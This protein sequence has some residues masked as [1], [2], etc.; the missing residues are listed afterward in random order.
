LTALE[1]IPGNLRPTGHDIK[2]VIG[3]DGVELVDVLAPGRPT[4]R[5]TAAEYEAFV[6]GVRNGEFD[7][8][9]LTSHHDE[10]GSGPDG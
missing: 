8:E 7:W 6:A 2:V 10:D 9:T 4:I 1:D 3:D 5:L